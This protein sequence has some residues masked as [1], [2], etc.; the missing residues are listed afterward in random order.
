MWFGRHGHERQLLRAQRSLTASCK[1]CARFRV[2]FRHTWFL[3]LG[4]LG[5]SEKTLQPSRT[6]AV[7]CGHQTKGPQRCRPPSHRLHCTPLKHWKTG[8]GLLEVSGGAPLREDELQVEC[9]RH[10]AV[11]MSEGRPSGRTN[12]IP[13]TPHRRSSPTLPPPCKCHSSTPVPS[14][15]CSYHDPASSLWSRR[16]PSRLFRSRTLLYRLDQE[17]HTFRANAQDWKISSIS[18]T[19]AHAG[20]AQRR[21]T[22]G[23]QRRLASDILGLESFQRDPEKTCVLDA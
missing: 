13:L 20:S 10:T 19:C 4:P 8:G 15:D 17:K 23:Q 7:P 22:V 11:R 5:L 3:V 12:F 2:E 21:K 1:A 9:L 16:I 18:V 14:G 6:Q